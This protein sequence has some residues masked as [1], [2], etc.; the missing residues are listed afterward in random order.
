MTVPAGR[1]ALYLV[2]AGGTLPACDDG[3]GVV[4]TAEFRS[5][6]VTVVDTL[7]SP[8]G[9]AT[10]TATNLRTGTLLGPTS[11]ALLTPGTYVIVDDGSRDKLREAGDSVRVTAGRDASPVTTATYFI[12]V[13][14]GCHVEKVSGPDTLAVR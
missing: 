10:V 13:P 7:G 14:A 6:T 9:D 8:V 11:L 3:Q 12:S 5:I 4:C 1:I 2:L